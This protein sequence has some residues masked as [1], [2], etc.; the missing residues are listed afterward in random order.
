MFTNMYRGELDFPETPVDEQE[1]EE[2]KND[3]H[4]FEHDHKRSAF[5]KT[6]V[7]GSDFNVK[8]QTCHLSSPSTHTFESIKWNVQET[9][10]GDVMPFKMF[11]T[12]D[13]GFFKKG[14][15]EW[16]AGEPYI[17]GRKYLLV[18]CIR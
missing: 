17:R 7:I 10:V 15:I 12:R 13:D 8:D 14:A 4:I 16:K 3:A 5:I 6:R 9:L 2:L 18:E 11:W 1:L